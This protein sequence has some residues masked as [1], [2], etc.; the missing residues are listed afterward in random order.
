MAV[1][2]TFCNFQEIVFYHVAVLYT[3]FTFSLVP[4]RPRSVEREK[5]AWGLRPPPPFWRQNPPSGF[6]C[7]VVTRWGSQQLD[8]YI[9]KLILFCISAV[10]TE[11]FFDDM[12]I[13]LQSFQISEIFYPFSVSSKSLFFGIFYVSKIGNIC[14]IYQNR[15]VDKTLNMHLTYSVQCMFQGCDR[16]SREKHALKH[17]E[18]PR[19]SCHCLVINTTSWTVW[20]DF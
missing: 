6:V 3:N 10:L 1:L 9:V 14:I 7:S 8:P 2:Y 15:Y 20:W 4:M 17:Y 18:T 12:W 19:S 16:N 11:N 13:H 5:P